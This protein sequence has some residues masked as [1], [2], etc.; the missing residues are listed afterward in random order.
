MRVDAMERDSLISE[1]ASYPPG[2]R[3]Y[4]SRP[5][6]AGAFRDRRHGYQT[7]RKEG[8]PKADKIIH[9]AG[10]GGLEITGA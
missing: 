2:P 8:E 5:F 7:L 10:Q 3:L 9:K 1:T 4:S 6:W